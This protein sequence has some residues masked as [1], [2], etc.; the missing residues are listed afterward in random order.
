MFRA[1]LKCFGDLLLRV[2][3]VEIKKSGFNCI[4]IIPLWFYSV[5]V[6]ICRYL[7]IRIDVAS[8]IKYR[9]SL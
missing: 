8:Y 9:S 5:D 3:F 6:V 2:R 7:W 1:W 4:N